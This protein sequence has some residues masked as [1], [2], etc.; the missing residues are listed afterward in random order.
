VDVLFVGPNDLSAN[1]GVFRQFDSPTFRDA[2]ER[3]Q[4]TAQHHGVA[5]GYMAGSADEV[6]QRID[7]GF[8]FVAA[9]TDARLL[10]AA[11][12]ST[13]DKIR[14]GLTERAAPRSL[15]AAG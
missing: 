10:A 6:L 12:K 7:Q 11:M 8:R 1:L 2:I 5:T 14:E 13:Y 3:I 9:G 15:K 4:K